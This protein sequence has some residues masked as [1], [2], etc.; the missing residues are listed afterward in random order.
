MT[1]A[2]KRAQLL[3]RELDSAFRNRADLYRL[4]LDELCARLGPSEAEAAMVKVVEQRGREVAAAAFSSF[5]PNDARA[6]GRGVSGHQPGFGAH[7][8]RRCGARRPSYR[9]QGAAL[10][11]EGCLGGGRSVGRSPRDALPDRRRLRPGPF[12]SSRCPLFQPH[13]DPRSRK[14]LLSHPPRGS[15]PTRC[16]KSRDKAGGGLFASRPSVLSDAHGTAQGS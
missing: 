16:L 3:S 9:V 4:F 1:D 2:N 11:A 15:R 8:S 12:R 10:P 7:V 6:L 13:L 14:R 5:G